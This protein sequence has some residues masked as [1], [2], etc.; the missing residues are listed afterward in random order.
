MKN[1]FK[2][3]LIATA[4]LVIVGLFMFSAVCSA[5]NYGLKGV[6]VDAGLAT[7]ETPG[8]GLGLPIYIGN[9]VG[10]AMS[11]VAIL[12]FILM[13]YGGYMWLV[14]RGNEEMSKKGTETIFGAIIGLIIVLGAYVLTNFIFST[15]EGGRTDIEENIVADQVSMV[16]QACPQESIHHYSDKIVGQSVIS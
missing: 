1:V 3:N 12:F 9:V 13:V 4:L 11:L 16:G 8:A 6:A 10:T 15:V 2:I 14:S 7:E 5:G